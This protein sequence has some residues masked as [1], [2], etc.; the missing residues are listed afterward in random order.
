MDD[1]KDKLYGLSISYAYDMLSG[2]TEK[3]DEHLF[4]LSELLG[5]K[6]DDAWNTAKKKML[7]LDM[8][9][10]FNEGLTI[11]FHAMKNDGIQCKCSIEYLLIGNLTGKGYETSTLKDAEYGCHIEDALYINGMMKQMEKV[12]A[13]KGEQGLAEDLVGFDPFRSRQFLIKGVIDPLLDKQRK[14]EPN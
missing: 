1:F 11:D 14:N 8:A 9:S 2:E 5:V 3:A 7:V 13:E 10:E 4:N 12:E 6:K